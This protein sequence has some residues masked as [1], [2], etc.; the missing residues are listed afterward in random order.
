VYLPSAIRSLYALVGLEG[1]RFQYR[2]IQNEFLMV[3]AFA[4]AEINDSVF[5]AAV[6]VKSA[7]AFSIFYNFCD[8]ART[9][10]PT[11]K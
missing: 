1:S 11:G 6:S 8:I 4:C 9:P 10:C 3:Q 7:S 5:V 2:G